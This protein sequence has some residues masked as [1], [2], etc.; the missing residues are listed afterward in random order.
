[1]KAKKKVNKQ[2]TP[3]FLEARR[4]KM[5]QTVLELECHVQGRMGDFV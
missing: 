3:P 5:E 4:S 1:M 2:T